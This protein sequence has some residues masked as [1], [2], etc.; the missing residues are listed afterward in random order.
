MCDSE[1]FSLVCTLLLVFSIQPLH[2]T[3]DPICRILHCINESS[4]F[5]LPFASLSVADVS[6]NP[7]VL[8]RSEEISKELVSS[9]SLSSRTSVALC[10]NP[11]T[12]PCT[13]TTPSNSNKTHNNNHLN[14]SQWHNSTWEEGIV[15]TGMPG[16]I[17]K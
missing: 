7:I 11:T 13:T 2:M 12:T 14:N 5:T 9:S 15:N 4:Y 8:R 17:S 3:H 6:H 1:M 16:I 10:Q